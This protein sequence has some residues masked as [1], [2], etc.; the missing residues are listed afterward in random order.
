MPLVESSCA[1]EQLD[2]ALGL[3]KRGVEESRA[4]LPGIVMQ[5]LDPLA[6]GDGI[7][8]L[9]SERHNHACKQ[10]LLC[11]LDRIIGNT[12]IDEREKAGHGESRPSELFVDA[13]QDAVQSKEKTSS[14]APTSKHQHE[15]LAA[16]LHQR[17]RGSLAANVPVC[18]LLYTSPSPRDS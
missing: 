7:L 6:G 15:A 18:C 10:A 13:V 4:V 14:N 12:E 5:R 9:A 1:K 3:Q 16:W 8:Q 2:Q 11:L 17:A